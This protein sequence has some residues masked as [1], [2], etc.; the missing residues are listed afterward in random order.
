M[1]HALYLPPFGDFSDPHATVDLAIVAE[2]AGWDGIFLWDHM[3]RQPGETTEIADTWITLAAVASATQRLRLG[4]AITPLSR[5]RPQKVAREAITLDRLS[6]GR[7]TLGVGLGVNTGGELERFGESTDEDIR[8]DMLDEAL[9]V[10]IGLWSGE[11]VDHRGRYFTAD[12]VRFQPGPVQQPRI[13]IWGAARGGCGTRPLRRA[14]RLDGLF[15]VDT[16]IDQL[17]RMLDV[18]AAERGSME[19]FDVAMLALVD[20]DLQPLASMGVTWAM[21]TVNSREATADVF[22]FAQAGPGS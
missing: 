10:I 2:E 22:K 17:A 15:P 18:V 14:A 19:G 1:R 5:R 4:P 8:A 12:Q 9:E 7:L 13:P 21:W 11:E 20:T 3:W 16:S 6:D